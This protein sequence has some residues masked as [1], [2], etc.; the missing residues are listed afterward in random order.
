M[1]F[2]EILFLI[3]LILM[4]NYSY[5]SLFLVLYGSRKNNRS[6][7]KKRIKYPKVSII[8]PLRDEP[9]RL[10][11]GLIDNIMSLKY[12]KDK[13]EIIVIDDSSDT[14]EKNKKLFES[15]LTQY[16]LKYIH[17]KEN[18]GFKPG[19]LNDALKIASGKILACI[20]V[21]SR[22]PKTALIDAVSL[23]ESDDTSYVQYITRPI[24]RNKI[25][26]GYSIYIEFRNSVFQPA[27][28]NFE[29]P[30]IIGYGFFIKKD[31]IEKL[32]G[33]KENALAEDL[34][35]SMRLS[36]NGYKGRLIKDRYVLETAPS[37]YTSLKKQ[38][39]RWIFGAFQTFIGV[40]KET[41]YFVDKKIWLTY[42]VLTSMFLS[43]A[44]NFIISLVP[45]FSFLLN[46]KINM[47]YF[48]TLTT[49]NNIALGLVGIKVIVSLL[50]Y[51]SLKD[52]IVGFIIGGVLYNML[53]LKTLILFFKALFNK[54]MRWVVT[55]KAD[56]YKNICEIDYATIFA[57]LLY[58]L[59]FFLSIFKAKIFTLWMLSLFASTIFSLFCEIKNR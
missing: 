23:L 53:S 54:Q 12:R 16:T 32:G 57:A 43:L 18:R 58:G 22:L 17:R 8:I 5:F 46:E 7:D 47:F 3:S 51:Q 20:D 11:D 35:L 39:E 13:I 21:D 9:S 24:I 26:K 41:K 14:W 44:S 28:D 37:L 52:I 30:L 40:L 6:I 36:K 31:V 56:S 42:V 1:Y 4:I 34:D 27:F 59:A 50:R 2:S 15:R 10:I 33:W 38:Q 29:R 25:S 55:I 19:A 49:I 45:I 48:V